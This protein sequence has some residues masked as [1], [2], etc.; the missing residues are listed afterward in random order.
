VA[1]GASNADETDGGNT[2]DEDEDEDEKDEEDE[3]EE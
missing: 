3:D 2:A 1:E